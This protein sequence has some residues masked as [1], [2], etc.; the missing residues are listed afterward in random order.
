MASLEDLGITRAEIDAA[1]ADM[2]EL[3]PAK[4]KLA[5]KAAEY[6]RRI[7]PVETG[8]YRDSIHV[9]VRGEKVRVVADD[10]AATYIEFGTNDTPEFAPRSKTSAKF[11][12][13]N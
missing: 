1:I 6:W 11:A 8:Q 7:A 10:E 3:L 4:V 2:P 5:E 13:G 9:E 12:G